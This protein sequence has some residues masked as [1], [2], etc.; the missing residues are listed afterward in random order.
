MEFPRESQLRIDQFR[1]IQVKATRSIF[2][3]KNNAKNLKTYSSLSQKTKLRL[4]HKFQE[5]KRGKII[6]SS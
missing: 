5:N 4:K 6:K 3:E 2:A 1:I